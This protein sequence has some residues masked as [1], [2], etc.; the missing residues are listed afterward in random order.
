MW[1]IVTIAEFV[2][3]PRKINANLDRLDNCSTFQMHMEIQTAAQRSSIQT[4]ATFRP[5]DTANLVYK[6]STDVI[7]TDIRACFFGCTT[8]CWTGRKERIN[9]TMN[10]NLSSYIAENTAFFQYKTL[11]MN[12]HEG[13]SRCLL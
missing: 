5:T 12:L 9:A 6:T 4:I 11:E 1:V 13:K 7:Y 8:D 3:G 10:L 2:L